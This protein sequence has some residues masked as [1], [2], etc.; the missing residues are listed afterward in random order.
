M[1]QI[2]SR[3]RVYFDGVS[4]WIPNTVTELQPDLL[5]SPRT[6]YTGNK[7]FIVAETCLLLIA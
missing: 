5:Y 1:F 4:D 6:D 2:M 3:A 7:T